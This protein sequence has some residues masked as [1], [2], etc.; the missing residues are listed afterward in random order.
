MNSR[1]E[2]HANEAEGDVQRAN[3]LTAKVIL[4][5]AAL[6][7]ISNLSTNI[8]L[9]AFPEMARQLNVSSQQLG[10]TLSSFFITFAFAQLLVG[11]LADRYGRKRLVDAEHHFGLARTFHSRR[12][13]GNPY[14]AVL[15]QRD[16]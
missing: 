6:A 13:V 1:L 7:A 12:H 11:P 8:I 4:L 3:V 15:P 5:L 16:R 9:P 10:L 14:R 2:T